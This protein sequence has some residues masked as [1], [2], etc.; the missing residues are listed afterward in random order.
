M[1]GFL[2][3]CKTPEITEVLST[4]NIGVHEGGRESQNEHYP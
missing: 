4:S 1:V 3:G 2:V